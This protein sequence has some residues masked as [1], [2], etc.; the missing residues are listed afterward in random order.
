MLHIVICDLMT[1]LLV[2]CT[3]HTARQVNVYLHANTHYCGYAVMPSAA[4][5]SQRSA[6][7]DNSMKKSYQETR[8]MQNERE[9]RQTRIDCFNFEPVSVRSQNCLLQCWVF[10]DTNLC[11][12]HKQIL[13]QEFDDKKSRINRIKWVSQSFAG[14]THLKSDEIQSGIRSNVCVSKRLSCTIT[15]AHSCTVE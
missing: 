5:N 9:K 2:M 13:L 15:Y 11:S 7:T 14:N 8:L 1:I 10:N 4:S 6:I 3:A 12:V